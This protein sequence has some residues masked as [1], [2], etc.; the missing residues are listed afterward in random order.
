M[1]NRENFSEMFKELKNSNAELA[2]MTPSFA[3][4]LLLDNS[5]CENLMPNLKQIIFCGEK[6]LNTTVKKLYS[7]FNNL[8]IINCYGPTECTFA[9]TSM[10]IPRDF[11]YEE[12]PV[13]IPKDDVEIFILDEY[14]NKLTQGEIGEILIS[15][16]SVAEGY[17][18]KVKNDS[19]IQFEEKKAYLTGDLGYIKNGILYYK[20]RKDKQ[21]KYKGY[22]IELSDIEKNLQKLCY[23]EKCVVIANSNKNGKVTNLIAFAKLK[24][25]ITKSEF[26]IRQ[27][28][29]KKIPEYMIPKI[30]II[31]EFPI[32]QNGKC[33]EKRL[34]EE[35]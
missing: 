26:E 31:G 30:K 32:N 5:F 25:N 2:V 24:E 34:L 21:V 35:Y 15:G 22:R 29:I 3:D 6:L 16:E 27:E 18:G 23:I 1:K 28:L 8:K 13:G 10:E 19:F 7:R 4:L 20:A 14:K 9:V 11:Q 17:L 33:D 12:I